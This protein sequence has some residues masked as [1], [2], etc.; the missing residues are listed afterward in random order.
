MLGMSDGRHVHVVYPGMCPGGSGPDF[1]DAVLLKDDGRIE[2]GDVELHLRAGDWV[3][4]GH[5]RDPLYNSVVLHV[6]GDECDPR[7]TILQNGRC[8]PTARFPEPYGPDACGILPC[9]GRAALLPEVIT[10]LLLCAGVSR[11]LIRAHDIARRLETEEHGRMLWL[12]AARVLGYASNSDAMELL[13]THLACEGVLHEISSL[14]STK[15]E[16]FFLGAAGL[17]P[18]Q[19][20]SCRAIDTAESMPWEHAWT[21]LGAGI[22]PSVYPWRMSGVYPNNSPVRRVAA[23]ATLVLILE[24]AVDAV[25]RLLW[26]YKSERRTSVEEV[27]Q[28]FIIEGSPYWRKHYDFGLA[29]RECHV[30]GQSKARE[31]V[32]NAV[33]PFLA[34]EAIAAGDDSLLDSL[35]RLY[36]CYPKTSAN[37]VTRHMSRQLGYE[38]PRRSAAVLQGMLH[39]YANYCSQGLCFACPMAAPLSC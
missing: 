17:L 4:H 21:T 39:I 5:T 25:R 30:N 8:V 38:R 32:I 19:R 33:L 7:Q 22:P 34:G 1:R 14:C 36:V 3:S 23:M 16:A 12:R 11:L 35:L 28:C 13:A 9:R 24:D 6:I 18:S 31:L 37:N 2:R 29:T 10:H 15:R 20:E 27:E 26:E